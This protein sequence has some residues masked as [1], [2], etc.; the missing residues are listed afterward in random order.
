ME[1]SVQVSIHPDP[2]DR[3]SLARPRNGRSGPVAR[4]H[5]L[6]MKPVDCGGHVLSDGRMS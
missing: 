5:G 2:I 1:P 3:P 6:R 4:R